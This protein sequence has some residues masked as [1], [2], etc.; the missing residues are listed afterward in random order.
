MPALVRGEMQ[1]E[2]R[3]N[4]SA[5]SRPANPDTAKITDLLADPVATDKRAVHL[6]VAARII[7]REIVDQSA[8]G[9]SH[10]QSEIRHV[11]GIDR[12]VHL[13]ERVCRLREGD[14]IGLAR[15]GG[16]GARE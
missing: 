5:A 8:L 15:G 11:A 2:V 14:T 16:P 10:N 4:S 6:R 12:V 7:V 13:V 9:L 1:T 3:R